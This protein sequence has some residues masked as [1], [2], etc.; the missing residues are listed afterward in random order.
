MTAGIIARQCFD[1]A[2]V[3]W[4]GMTGSVWLSASAATIVAAVTF[5]FV[6][7]SRALDL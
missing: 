5:L 3:A 4:L 1:G 7:S 6:Y 2:F